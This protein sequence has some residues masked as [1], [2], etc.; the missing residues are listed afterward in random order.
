M[1]NSTGN[2]GVAG[3]SNGE[4]GPQPADEDESDE[5][6]FEEGLSPERGVS[7]LEGA[8]PCSLLISSSSSSDEWFPSL[9]SIMGV[10]VIKKAGVTFSFSPNSDWEERGAGLVNWSSSSV[11]SISE[12]SIILKL[13]TAFLID[14]FCFP[15]Q[16]GH[17]KNP[18]KS[19]YKILDEKEGWRKF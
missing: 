17:W 11:K 8:W 6:E 10:A 19:L 15:Q 14:G 5:T 16:N 9:G 4:I 2:V 1:E 7:G 18:I 13:S 3:S 12:I